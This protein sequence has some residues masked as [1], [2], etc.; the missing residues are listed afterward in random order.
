MLRT[1][2]S[3]P[4]S[5]WTTVSLTWSPSGSMSKVT[6]DRRSAARVAMT[7]SVS[8]GAYVLTSGPKV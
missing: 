7:S 5:S 4:N 6:R 2:L 8:A 1:T 3:G